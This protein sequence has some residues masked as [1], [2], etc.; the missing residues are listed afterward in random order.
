MGTCTLLHKC[1]GTN[2]LIM[3]HVTKFQN[4]S[5]ASGGEISIHDGMQRI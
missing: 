4:I 5:E 2:L 3:S 1:K